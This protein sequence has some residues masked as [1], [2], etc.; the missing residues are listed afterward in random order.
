M[1]TIEK[2]KAFVEVL[3]SLAS[4]ATWNWRRRP[5]CGSAV[6]SKRGNYRCHPWHLHGQGGDGRGSESA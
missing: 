5:C 6:T 4:C 2:G 3:V 1:D